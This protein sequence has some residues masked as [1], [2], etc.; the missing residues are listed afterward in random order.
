MHEHL[1]EKLLLAEVADA[2]GLS[3]YR[4]AHLF[5]QQ[6]G[7]TPRQYLEQERMRRARHLLQRS[8]QPIKEIATALGFESPFHFSS[9]FKKSTGQSPQA[10]RQRM[11]H[12]PLA[13][14]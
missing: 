6:V 12:T 3:V 8:T 7:L 1:S 13:H 10:F 9:R 11:R 14:D 5:R 4:F 2:V